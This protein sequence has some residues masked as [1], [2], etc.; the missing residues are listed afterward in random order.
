MKGLLPRLV[1]MCITYALFASISMRLGW[2]KR[3]WSFLK[4]DLKPQNKVIIWLIFVVLFNILAQILFET[5]GINYNE[6]ISGAVLGIS[7]AFMPTLY[8]KKED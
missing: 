8:E 1:T 3:I 5:F 2:G 6:V 4:H 7:L